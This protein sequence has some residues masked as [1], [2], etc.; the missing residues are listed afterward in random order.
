MNNLKIVKSNRPTLS[1]SIDAK[2]PLP[3][4]TTHEK[5]AELTQLGDNWDGYGALSPTKEAL[6]GAM[7]LAMELFEEGTPLPDVFPVPNGNI[8]LEWSCFGFDLEIE[9]ISNRKLIACFD[10]L[11]TDESWE[12]PFTFELTELRKVI[13]ELTLRNQPLPRM[14]VVNG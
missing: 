8:Q 9:V 7:Q 6:I 4:I 13:E 12:K 2:Y 3:I 10:N 5:V 11:A 14:R 1:T